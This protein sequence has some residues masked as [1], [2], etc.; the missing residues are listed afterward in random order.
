MLLCV[1]TA[2]ITTETLTRVG[3]NTPLVIFEDLDLLPVR[4][5]PQL[6]SSAESSGVTTRAESFHLLLKLYSGVLTFSSLRR[7][8]RPAVIMVDAFPIHSSSS[9]W[10]VFLSHLLFVF[11]SD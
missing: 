7:H 10:G 9:F 11:I 8:L 4:H 2:L 3:S 6:K 1:L 5:T